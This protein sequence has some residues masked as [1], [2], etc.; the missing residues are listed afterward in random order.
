[1]GVE[2]ERRVRERKGEAF[3][4]D[5]NLSGKGKKTKQSLQYM[6]QARAIIDSHSSMTIKCM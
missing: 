1:M 6:L 4:W 3:E 5:R 2:E